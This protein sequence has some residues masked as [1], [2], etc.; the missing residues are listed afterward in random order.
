MS[1]QVGFPRYAAIFVSVCLSL[2]VPALL[3]ADPGFGTLRKKKLELE[4]RQPAVVRLA[5][6]SFAVAGSA[7]RAYQQALDSLMPTLETEL[8]AN[9]KTL[10][11]KPRGEAEFVLAVRITSFSAPPAQPKVVGNATIL[12]WNGSLRL[13]Y[14]VLGRSGKVFAASNVNAI[15]DKDAQNAGTITG[16]VNTVKKIPIPGLRKASTPEREPQTQDDLRQ[17]LVDNAVQQIA[18]KLG[19]TKQTLPVEVAGGDD[20][21]NRAA[22]FMD[23]QLWSRA[24]DELESTP[25]FA[26]PDSEAYRQYDLG[27]VHEAMS[28][29]AKTLADQKANLIQAQEY[30]DK[31]LEM[32]R[33][34]KYFVVTVARTRDALARYK[35]FEGM[36]REDVKAAAAPP[37]PPVPPPPQPVAATPAPKPV[38]QTAQ[39]AQVAVK[40]AAPAQSVPRQNVAPAKPAPTP[41][42]ATAPGP[43]TLKIGD[44]IEMYSAKVPEDQI[45]AII[46]KSA[47][48][49]DPLDKDTAIAIARVGLP[50][51]LQNEMRSR[52][53]APLLG[54][55]KK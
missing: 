32:N 18:S 27:L 42:P 45:T 43:K 16:A 41:A 53:G 26:K 30:Y 22:D 7:D 3:C 37:P 33:K 36:Q 12:H 49:F 17:V 24:L 39:K 20:R 35:A 47:V 34:E 52:V 48:Q 5:N 19:N 6:T 23:K 13:A 11:K 29:E 46:R 4:I 28:Y 55:A 1:L 10:V 2:V 38:Q 21:L 31:A 14:Q 44:V 50:V 51:S 8:L 54:G 25:P 40:T 15:Y 9:E